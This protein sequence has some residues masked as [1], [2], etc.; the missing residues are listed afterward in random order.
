MIK[1]L[2]LL[3]I[4]FSNTALADNTLKASKFELGL[5]TFTF[6]A[7][8]YLGSSHTQTVLLPFPMIKYRGEKLKIDNGVQLK[9]LDQ[10]RW[11]IS[12][13]GNGS[14]P[15]S[16]QNHEREGMEPLDAT[17][18]LGPSIDYLLAQTELTNLWINIPLRFTY[19]VGS[20]SGYIGKVLNPKISWR[21]PATLKYNWKLGLTAGLIFA[22]EDFNRYYYEVRPEEATDSRPA[23]Q[24]QAGYNG[25]RTELT[26]SRRVNKFWIGGFLRYDNLSQN[27]NE[28]SPLI[29]TQ[30]NWT[31]GVALSWVIKEW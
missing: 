13:S 1:T 30:D 14:L 16:E 10:D 25:L 31:A 7:P 4:I 18:E 21:K 29:T 3:L 26:F 19:G 22:D 12:I 11:L 6:S 17:V 8:D 23:Y 15:S 5:G 9:I 28:Q 20:N 27:V 24:A 2:I